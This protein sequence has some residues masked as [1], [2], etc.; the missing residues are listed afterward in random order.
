MT[1]HEMNFE[2]VV[3]T[4]SNPEV[5]KEYDLWYLNLNG[6]SLGW[7][8]YEKGYPI[9]SVFRDLFKRYLGNW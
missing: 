5:A 7:E 1:I 9:S 2:L 3:R 8:L 4:P 6:T